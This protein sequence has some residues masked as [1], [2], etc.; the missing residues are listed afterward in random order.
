MTGKT[1]Q[2]FLPMLA[3][4]YLTMLQQCRRT[5]I[6]AVILLLI[7]GN[8]IVSASGSDGFMNIPWGTSRGEVAKRMAELNFPKDPESNVKRDIYEGMF[9]GHKAYLTFRFINDV[10]YSGGAL[11][12]D[13]Y[14][15]FGDGGNG[16]IDYFFKD[17]ETQ[18]ISKYGNPS[19][20]PYDDSD[21]WNIEE[22]GTRI[23]IKLGKNYPQKGGDNGRVFLNYD[24]QTFYEKQKQYVTN[25]DL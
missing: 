4:P 24:N 3:R 17:F 5:I 22:Q 9:A 7:S 20:R 11:F 18:I 14:R 6:I 13:T 12:V 25:R 1:K 16:I 19:K 8:S 10:F 21:Y 2:Y 23:E 15:A